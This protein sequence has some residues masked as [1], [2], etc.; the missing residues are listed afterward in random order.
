MGRLVYLGL[1]AVAGFFSLFI[2]LFALLGTCPFNVATHW[3]CYPGKSNP[4]ACVFAGGEVKK[5]DFI[6]TENP[7]ATMEQLRENYCGS[8]MKMRIVKDHEREG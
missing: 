3:H 4:K 1:G 5:F 6:Y 2:T 7:N 8:H